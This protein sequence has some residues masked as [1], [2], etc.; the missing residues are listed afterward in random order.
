MNSG[1]CTVMPPWNRI[2]LLLEASEGI[3][4]VVWMSLYVQ[5]RPSQHVLNSLKLTMIDGVECS[6]YV[7]TCYDCVVIQTF[8]SL[9]CC[10]AAVKETQVWQCDWWNEQCWWYVC[11]LPHL[12]YEPCSYHLFNNIC[13]HMFHYR[14]MFISPD[15]HVRYFLQ[16]E[17]KGN[18]L[19][20]LTY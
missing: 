13:W 20:F 18:M 19:T 6:R 9:E 2:L 10:T 4:K 1:S 17:I 12:D 16:K 15:G 14:K 7:E 3:V 5:H 11:L 8:I